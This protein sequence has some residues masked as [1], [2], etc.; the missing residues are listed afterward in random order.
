MNKLKIHVLQQKALSSLGKYLF[1][2]VLAFLAVSCSKK[3]E[4][5]GKVTGGSPLERIE[6]TEASGVATLPVI[7]MGVDKDG[8]FKGDFDAPKSGMYVISYAGK[9]NLIY[10]K[11][12]QSLNITGDAATFPAEF[13]ITGDAKGNNDFLQQTQ[14]YMTEYTQKVNMQDNMNKDEGAFLKALQK[15][16]ADLEK[17]IDEVGKKTGADKEVIS[18]KKN[19]VRTG[20]MSIIPQYEMYRKQMTANPA[21]ANSKAL[22]DYELKLQEDKDTMVKEHPLYRNYLLGKMSEDF[23]KYATAQTAG[24]T[25]MITSE[26]FSNYLKQRKDLSQTAK[27]YLLAFVMA[28]SDINPSSTKETTDKVTSIIDKDIK[29]AE[30]KKDLKKVLFVLSGLKKGEAAPEAALIKQDGKAYKIADSKG[31]PTVMMF[32]ASWTPYITESTVPI[33]SQVVDFYK[34]KMNFV[35]VNFDDTKEQ[36]NK[37]SSAMLKGIPGTN[38]YAEGGLNSDF[39]KKYGIYGFKLTP[40]FI[41]LDKDGKIAGRNF[42]NLGDPELVALLDQLSGLKAPQVAPEAS[43]QNDLFAPEGELQPEDGS[44][45]PPPAPATK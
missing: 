10:L 25:D 24:K 43:L 31:K 37:T 38:V 16:Q 9:Q 35:F 6:F 1:M 5:T 8:N 44:T 14:K 41:V 23:Q 28:Q 45:P 26:V 30:I 3:V 2:M 32:Y 17:N 13:K 27:D 39:A 15:I 11:T 40:S 7:N 4:V 42:F 19:D 22:K 20:I 36:F 34:Q 29:D 12:G 33:L 21:F 18:W